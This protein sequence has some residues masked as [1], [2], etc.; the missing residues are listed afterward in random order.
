M[1]TLK[2]FQF[3][4]LESANSGDTAGHG[5]DIFSRSMPLL[6]RLAG[7]LM[8]AFKEYKGKKMPFVAAAFDHQ[9]S[10]YLV[11]GRSARSSLEKKYTLLI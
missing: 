9:T 1:K 3:V 5:E 7:F 2:K 10:H 6:H 4:I 8:D 11:I